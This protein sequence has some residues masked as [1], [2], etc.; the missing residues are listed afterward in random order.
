[1]D[2]L[3]ILCIVGGEF[4]DKNYEYLMQYDGENVQIE[5]YTDAVKN[6]LSLGRILTL[7]DSMNEGY[8]GK[9]YFCT[10]IEKL[11]QDVKM[12][13]KSV[14]SEILLCPELYKLL[15]EYV[16]YQNYH[17]EECKQEKMIDLMQS[18]NK[19]KMYCA[20]SALNT[21]V[22]TN[23][24]G[25]Y[26]QLDNLIC[27]MSETEQDIFYRWLEE[28]SIPMDECDS[29]FYI[30]CLSVLLCAKKDGRYAE[31]I[32]D[33][34][35]EGDYTV[36][37]YFYLFHQLKRFY[38][39]YP[40]VSNTPQVEKLYST[41]LM[42]WKCAL[43]ELLTK[44][45]REKR[46]KDK[47]VV[48]VLQ[49]LGKRHA[50][51]KTALERIETIGKQMNRDVLVIHSREQLTQRGEIPFWG[52]VAGNVTTDY[53]GLCDIEGKQGYTFTM[54]QPAVAMPEY[55]EVCKI[56]QLIR[57][58]CPY[59][60]VMLGDHCLLGD[61]VAEM[62]P[63]VCIP[64]VFSSIPIKHNQF[65]AV[66]KHL[67]N[68]DYQMIEAQGCERVRY[69]E[70]T[71]TFELIPQTTTLT[72]EQLRL[73]ED[74]FI[75]SMVGIR[76]DYEITE[77]FIHKI[78]RVFE[79]GCYIAFAGTFRTYEELCKRIPDLANNSTYVGYQ[80]DIL[81]F[82]EIC[83]LYVN[84]PRMGGGFSVVEA[85]H[86]GKPGVT[87]PYGDVAASTG[88]EFWVKDLDEMAETII[89]YKEDADFYYIQSVR[90][91]ERS[92]KLFDSRGAM[93]HILNEMEKREGFF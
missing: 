47:V 28:Y 1:M 91:Q 41:T 25:Y 11:Y 54:Y 86:K 33:E 82:Q 8:E 70:S 57:E 26:S 3:K 31:M 6:G 44:I 16:S 79:H 39:K 59:E 74:K 58:F 69:I 42:V 13:Y 87:L 4:S 15:D 51:T 62:I 80:N 2:E 45:P 76:L 17:V 49:F 30:F 52:C 77:S 72:R 88:P 24:L 20:D 85:F 75:L 65:V 43:K 48:I 40:Y 12:F 27:Q 32:C 93:E 73:P 89:R 67:T 81:A 68:E 5:L 56:L 35:L 34:I 55:T 46:N 60:V 53:D 14:F 92:R 63:T 19:L 38:W 83:D 23:I 37:Q 29:L 22:C 36:E 50:P 64:M 61:L 71:F 78:E 21:D 7:C 18:M 10:D 84:P 9:L 66:G 90:A